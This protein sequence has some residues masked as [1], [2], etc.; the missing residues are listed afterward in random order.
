[1][2]LIKEYL[3]TTFHQW[4]AKGMIAV[5]L[6]VVFEAIQKFCKAFNADIALVLFLLSVTFMGVA[7]HFTVLLKTSNYTTK[8]VLAGV[9]RLPLY[10]L[11]MFLVGILC[12]SVEHS[13]NIGVPALNLFIAY[14]VACESFSIV[15]SLRDLGVQVP[16]LL[17]FLVSDLKNRIERK[18]GG[19]GLPD[20]QK[21]RKYENM[22]DSMEKDKTHDIGPNTE[23]RERREGGK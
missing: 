9:F 4:Q 18:A 8:N 6:T 13:I 15:S 1:M 3:H 11:Y 20:C 16:T 19:S 14:L 5:I 7:L 23:R 21:T 10:C 22:P 17:L 2:Q 12:L